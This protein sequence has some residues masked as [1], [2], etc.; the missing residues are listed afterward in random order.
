MKKLLATTAIFAITACS[1]AP[2]VSSNPAEEANLQAKGKAVIEKGPTESAKAGG[3]NPVEFWQNRGKVASSYTSD[4][5]PDILSK[6]KIIY[7]VDFTV[8]FNTFFGVGE[9]GGHGM[10]DRASEN[11]SGMTGA[12]KS[13]SVKEKKTVTKWVDVTPEF[14]Q[15]VTD[16]AYAKFV[17]ELKAAGYEVR[18]RDQM[19][20]QPM[21]DY[22]ASKAFVASPLE[23]DRGMK[24]YAPTGW[25]IEKATANP[26]IG[27]AFAGFGDTLMKLSEQHSR[28]VSE[29][30]GMSVNYDINLGTVSKSKEDPHVKVTSGVTFNTTYYAGAISQN[31]VIKDGLK[32][33]YTEALFKKDD[34]AGGKALASVAAVMM[35]SGGSY[36]TSE[37]YAVKPD[38]AYLNQSVNEHLGYANDVLFER[39]R[40]GRD[41]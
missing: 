21:K 14:M 8:R 17:A 30:L 11:V 15:K 5:K 34:N 9:S 13:V 2:K 24:I 35:G 3:Y 29:S 33:K 41:D 22:L 31:K 16:D 18:T 39:I 20:Y 32:Y 36:N 27:D 10:F 7:L 28:K 12:S 1:S 23:G 19:N 6:S 37:V 4:M 40:Q 26:G 38:M 25:T